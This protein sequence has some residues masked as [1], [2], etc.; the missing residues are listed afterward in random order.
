MRLAVALT[1]VLAACS[2]PGGAVATSAPPVPVTTTPA[3]AARAT[4]APSPTPTPSPTPV[5]KVPV[6]SDAPVQSGLRVPW[7]LAFAPDGRMFVTER[8]GNVLIFE[9]G[10]PNARRIGHFSLSNVRAQGESGLMG[11]AFDPD[12]ARNGLL[13]VCASRTDEGEFR[14]QVLRLKVTGNE[15]DLDGFVIR[16]GMRAAA[17]HDGCIVRFGADAKLWVTMGDSTVS[18]LAQ[19]R[20]SLNGKILRVNTDGSIP[21]DNP[22]LPGRDAPSAIWSY[23]H[24]NPQGLAFQPGTGAVFEVEHGEDVHDEIN[25]LEKGANYGWPLA[26]GPDP[27]RRFK[28]PVWT[29]GGVTI[30]TS[31]G[32]FVTGAMW[33]TWSGSLFT[34]QLKDTD[35]RRFIVEGA[36]VTAAEILL[37]RKYGRLRSPVLGPDGALYITTS[38]G[39]GDRIVRVVATQPP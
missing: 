27:Q 38:N 1:A 31:G 21:S 19:D 32:T 33:G 24:R 39:T 16:S 11:I 37:D 26:E 6:L 15:I 25:V 34:A 36:K 20:S 12:F 29:S 3:T 2:S 17:A 18:A 9:S 7:D 14:N 28:D 5:P 13:Y 10:A 30:A 8:A 35:L 4:P 22:V 23:G